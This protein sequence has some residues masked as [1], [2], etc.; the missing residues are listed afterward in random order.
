MSTEKATAEVIDPVMDTAI[1]LITKA[2]IDTQIATAHA[3]PRSLTR[4]L[5]DVMTMATVSQEI[6]ESCVYALPRGNKTLQGPSVR[7][8]E[9]VASAYGNMRTGARVIYNDGKHVTAQGMVHDLEKN[10]MHTEEVKRS[11]LQN[12]KKW[13]P[14]TGKSENTGK[15]VPMNEDMQTVTGRAAC[16]I[17]YRNAIFKVVPAA[18][19]QDIYEKVKEIA[20]GTAET[21]VARRT[22]AMDYFRGLGVKDAQLF[23]A[24]QVKGIED[25]DLD[26]LQILTGMKSA[27]KNNESTIESLFPKPDAKAKADAANKSTEQK[28]QE[29]PKA[30]DSVRKTLDKL[31]AGIADLENKDPDP[32][33]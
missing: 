16:A 32:E 10:I 26:K 3:F 1:S 31:K 28:L 5:N 20:K 25:I 24:L 17:A 9:M 19:I 2:E 30:G 13:N 18:L 15:M 7:L 4:F 27:I 22:K 6:A 14:E 12:E 8:A 23:E 11:I 29:K 33:N 21:L